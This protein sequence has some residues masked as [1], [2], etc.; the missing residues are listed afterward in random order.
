MGFCSDSGLFPVV[1]VCNVISRQGSFI[2]AALFKHGTCALHDDLTVKTG[3]IKVI[4]DLPLFN[5]QVTV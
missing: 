1:E 5:W 3:S 2:Y 4:H